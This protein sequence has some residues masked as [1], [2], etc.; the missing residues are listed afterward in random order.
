MITFLGRETL[1]PGFKGEQVLTK[2]SLN[3]TKKLRTAFLSSS[4]EVLRLLVNPEELE[5][6]R[7]RAIARG[8]GKGRGQRG[9]GGQLGS[10]GTGSGGRGRGN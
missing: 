8:Q 2:P 3:Q 5:G 7:A 9:H 4:V 10:R 6:G 1:V